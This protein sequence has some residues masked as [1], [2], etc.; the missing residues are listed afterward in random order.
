M[1]W[2]GNESEDVRRLRG[3]KNQKKGSNMKKHG[4]SRAG[5]H[6]KETLLRR[7]TEERT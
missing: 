2:G 1:V 7:E 5:T 3:G 4:F 6:G